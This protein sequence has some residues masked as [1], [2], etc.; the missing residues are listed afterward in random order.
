MTKRRNL[1][2]EALEVYLLH[3]LLAFRPVFQIIGLLL[4]IYAVAALSLSLRV[5]FIALG[6]AFFLLLAST[7]FPLTLF[8]AK[9]GAWVGTLRK[10]NGRL[11]S[12]WLAV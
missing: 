9:L 11:R 12:F 8:M 1:D 3:L 7:F 6:L 4:L 10:K 2:R 5:N